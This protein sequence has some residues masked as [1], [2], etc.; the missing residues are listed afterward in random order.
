MTL[1]IYHS[2]PGSKDADKLTLLAALAATP[3]AT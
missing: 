3:A 2:V 1:V